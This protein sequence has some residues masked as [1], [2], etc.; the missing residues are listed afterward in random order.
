VQRLEALARTIPGVRTLDEAASGFSER[1]GQRG[2]VEE[3]DDCRRERVCGIGDEEVALVLDP[4]ALAADGCRDHWLL[5]REALHY[6][7]ARAAAGQ[8]RND[9][10][11]R[12]LEVGPDV[13]Y[14]AG[15]LHPRASHD[16]ELVDAAPT[17]DDHPRLG[18]GLPNPGQHL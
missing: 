7:D 9:H 12:S 16:V 17:D 18:V 5:H 14:L 8:D 6:L 15:R 13:R 4:D 2:A 3:P 10:E 11:L 1:P